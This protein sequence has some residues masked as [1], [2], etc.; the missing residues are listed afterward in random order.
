MSTFSAPDFV[1][2]VAPP[3][4]TTRKPSPLMAM[5][6]ALFVE[7]VPPCSVMFVVIDATCEPRPIC[8]ALLPAAF[9]R[10][11]GPVAGEVVW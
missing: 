7:D 2:Y 11:S 10:A 8:F 4:F 6:S 5:S 9:V 1:K 3:D